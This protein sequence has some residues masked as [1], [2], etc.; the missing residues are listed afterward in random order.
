V[1]WSHHHR[2]A[3]P[4]VARAE[5]GVVGGL[6][7][8]PFGVLIFV[9]GSLL[10]ANAWAVVDAKLATTAAAREAARS[11]VEAGSAVAGEDAAT[12]AAADVLESY[13]RDPDRLD[14]RLREAVP[15]TRCSRVTFVA[16][17]EIPAIALPFG[18]GLGGPIEV[19]SRHSEIIDPIRSGLPAEGACGF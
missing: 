9:V 16:S 6:E 5:R 11:Y 18:I 8:L 1:I 15:F 4:R 14:L 2:M 13:G 19:R 10:I 3:A 7:V 12:R 17:Y